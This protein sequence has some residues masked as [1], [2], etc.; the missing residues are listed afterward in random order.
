[1]KAVWTGAIVATGDGTRVVEGN[2][3]FPS[4][5]IDRSYFK[6]SKTMTH[7]PWKGIA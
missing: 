1:M 3:Y 5:S 2:H 4:D 6:A 7:C